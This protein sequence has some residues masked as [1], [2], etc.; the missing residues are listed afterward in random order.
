VRSE[1]RLFYLIGRPNQIKKLKASRPSRLG[2][3]TW[4]PT[5]F[6]QSTKKESTSAKLVK[7][8]LAKI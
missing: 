8:I 1:R 3:S 2:G 4:T 6:A 5:R 7:Y